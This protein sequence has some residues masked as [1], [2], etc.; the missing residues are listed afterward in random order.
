MIRT[1]PELPG[2]PGSCHTTP[3][4]LSAGRETVPGFAPSGRGGPYSTSS[5]RSAP[6]SASSLLPSAPLSLVRMG[7]VVTGVGCFVSG[8]TKTGNGCFASVG[9][10][11]GVGCF[12]SPGNRIGH[13]CLVSGGRTKPPGPTLIPNV[14]VG[15]GPTNVTGNAT[16]NA[17]RRSLRERTVPPSLRMRSANASISVAGPP[18][19][20]N[21]LAARMSAAMSSAFEA[22]VLSTSA[23]ALTAAGLNPR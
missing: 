4:P 22:A 20:D 17:L 12:V 19:P 23:N 1:D 14:P 13:G 15:R 10:G 8:R 21:A 11:T 7:G 18:S 6:S 2:A 5:S 3:L 9:P 16:R